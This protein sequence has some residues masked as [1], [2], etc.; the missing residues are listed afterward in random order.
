MTH[1][2]KDGKEIPISEMSDSH[3][4]NTILFYERKAKEGFEVVRGE[5]TGDLLESWVYREEMIGQ[6]ARKHLNLDEYLAE[7][8]RRGLQVYGWT[9]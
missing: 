3:L 2:T 8:T 7:A 6:E 4:R 5:C 9:Q 1:V